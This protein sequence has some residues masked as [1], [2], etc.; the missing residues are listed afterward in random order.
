MQKILCKK[1]ISFTLAFVSLFVFAFASVPSAKAEKTGVVTAT[2]LFIRKTP[3]TD[4]EKLR[5]LEEGWKITILDT[6]GDWLKVQYGEVIGYCAK[7]YIDQSGETKKSSESSSGSKKTVASLGDAPKASKPGDENSSVKKLQEALTILGY[8]D[9]RISGNYGELTE[10][11]V[12]DYQKAKGLSV[13]GIAGKGT[14]K[15]IFGSYGGDS[16]DSKSEEGKTEKLD[17][18]ADEGTKKI[19]KNAVVEIKDVWS[20][21]VFEAQRWSGASHLDAEPVTAEDTKVLKKC[22]GGTFS[23][24]RRPVLVKYNGHIYAGSMNGMPHGDST[25]KGNDFDGVFCIHFTNSKTHGSDKVDADHQKA[26]KEA[27]DAKW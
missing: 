11:A 22:Y 1:L 20:G 10:Q 25:I 13:D 12:R 8:Y 6:E 3:S 7:K 14:V 5:T 17:W 21:R 16:S 9:G 18:F 23:W 27:L 24:S 4:A 26:V 15:A 2:E 19:P